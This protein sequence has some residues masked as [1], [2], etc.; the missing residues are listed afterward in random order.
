M[1]RMSGLDHDVNRTK[2]IDKMIGFYCDVLGCTVEGRRY[3]ALDD[4]GRR[5][6]QLL[7]MHKYRAT[8]PPE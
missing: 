4:G 1:I 6:E 8:E 2:N 3:L 7:Y 5:S